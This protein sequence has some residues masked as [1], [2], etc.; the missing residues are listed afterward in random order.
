MHITGDKT[1][2]EAENIA[3]VEL[4]KVSTWAKQNKISFN[5]QKSKVMLTTR[6]KR[7]ESKD[8]QVY[9]NNK[10]LMQVNS[11]KYLGIILDCKLTFMD[12]INYMTEKCTKL[13]FALSKSAKLNW[14]VNHAALKAIYTGGILPLLQYG[15]PV[16]ISAIHKACYKLKL[17]RVRRLINIK[18]SKAYRTVSSE[19]LCIL[20]GLT[21]IAIKL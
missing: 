21:P 16:W 15:A 3:N 9:L 6:R 7:K 10:P 19:A 1:V 20:T 18:I 2:R 14:G 4:S 17:V 13:I 8:R 5:D 12:H 11:L